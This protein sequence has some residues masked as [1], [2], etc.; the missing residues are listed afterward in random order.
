MTTRPPRNRPA[1]ERKVLRRLGAA[2]Q[3]LVVG[4]TLAWT[5]QAS[6]ATTLADSPVFATSAVPGNVALALSVE[7]PTAVRSA[8]TTAYVSTETYLGYFDPNKCYLYQY[9]ATETATELRHF[10][11]NGVNTA[12]NCTGANEWSGNYL[13][14]ASTPTIDPFRWAMTGGY[15]II[16]TTTTTILQKSRDTGQGLAPDK[17]ITAAATVA[18]ASPLGFNNLHTRIQSQGI[19]MLFASSSAALGGAVADYNPA[20][21]PVVGTVYRAVMR[22]KVCDTATAAGGV[23]A[24]CKQYGSNWKPE[25][26]IQK[27]SNRIRFS[28]FGYLNHSDFLRDGAVLRAQQKFVGPT[29]PVPGEPAVTNAATEWDATTGVFYINPDA[30]D[31]TQTN[32]D[33]TPSVSITNSGVMNYLNKFG[34]LNTN[35]YKSYD[36]VSE[37]YY[38]ALR[39]FKNQ[40]NV[41]EYTTMGAANAATRTTYL[42]DFPVITNWNDPIQY[43]C[44][45]NFILGIGDIYT[46]R[47]KNLPGNTGRTDEP[48]VPALVSGDNTFGAGASVTTWT[49]NAFTLQGLAN[50]NWND[51]SGRANSAGIVGMAYYANT[52]D[53][54]PT[55]TGN[56]ATEGKQ[57]IQ[58]YWVDVL[59][60]P[61]VAD[62]QFYLAAKYGGFDVPDDYNAATRT[63]ALPNEWWSTTGQTVGAQNRP[64][65]YFTAGRPDTMVVGLTTAFEKIAAALEAFTTSFSTSVPQ[66]AVSGNGS[67]SAQYDPN[68]WTGQVQ[69][70][71]LSFNAVG[72]PT[73]TA[74]WTATSKLAA[75]LAG[76]GWDTNRNVVT[77]DPL[78][79]TPTGVAFRS[80]STGAGR[81]NATQLGLLDTTYRA[82]NDSADYLNYL[83]GDRTHE[84]ASTVTGS[85]RA[86]RTRTQLLG[87]IVGS[88]ARPV[89]PPSLPLSDATNPGYSTF[90]T[91][92]RT[93]PTVVYVG[94]NDGMLHAFNG[95]L[96]GA[97]AGREVFAYVPNA[98]FN[99]PDG[100][101]GVSGLA[102][103]G[104]SP[105]NHRYL[106]NATPTSYDVDMGK[107]WNGSGV[108]TSTNWRSVLIGGL[109]KGGRAYYAIDVTNPAGITNEAT[110]AANVLWEFTAPQMGYTFGEPVVVKTRKY[111]WT[112]ILP[113][114]YNT[115]DGQGYLFFVNPST[116][117][118]LETVATG[119]GSVANDAGLA[120]ANAYVV[121]FTDGY[122]DAV[123]AGDLLGNLWRFD[124]TGA[125]GTYPAP[126][127]LATL[128][129][130]TDGAQPVTSRPIIELHPRTKQRV[131]MVGTGRLL[132]DTDIASTQEQTFYAIA[133][134]NSVSFNTTAMLPT[135][136]TFPITRTQLVANTD[137]LTGYT[138][139]TAKP[140]GWFVDLGKNAGNNVAWRLVSDP[141]TFFGTVAFA[142]TLP[143]GDACSPSGMSR[144]YGTDFSNGLSKLT[145]NTTVV[146]Y[147]SGGTGVITDLRFLSVDGKVRLVSGSDRGAVQRV[148]GNFGTTIGLKRLNWR[149]LPL[150]N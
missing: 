96:T 28:A 127:R 42:D 4:S 104:R 111:G 138:A 91:T 150:S 64:D 146:S 141:T 85:T 21:A 17:S 53:I 107:T 101:P 34:Q 75:Q 2:A 13:N 25:G 140:M 70:S 27:Y 143:N 74:Q 105:L 132:A 44:Q 16:D 39:Y 54:R 113:S 5:L 19:N 48:A 35:D 121:D 81:V 131:V 55:V 72:D 11:P 22:V 38:T 60:Q 83:R 69:A 78:A 49:N 117:A 108:G 135:G 73:L 3:A 7:W 6:A 120:H 114:G 23:E 115:P 97:D 147:I 95:A 40:G 106:V 12:H 43:S 41:P 59:E 99:G 136:I 14:W 92:W 80:T 123:Y 119:V 57:T 134:G 89:G 37:L 93:R 129:H 56:V 82:D 125:S 109:G 24:N 79:A 67:Y 66:V 9:Y 112:V 45:R 30:T 58:T 51:Y 118:L 77:W 18:E 71:E 139:T 61:F 15:R 145:Q 130:P 32:T 124:V 86:Y 47:D 137:L 98:V 149:E 128:S 94:A 65:N 148:P 1:P 126:L 46:H 87:D 144:I 88:R 33:F 8:H 142:P 36:P 133:D 103:L 110:A 20:V 10:Y 31:A 26:L 122:A 116:G 90:R 62:N 76:T 68:N 29:R 52:T 63:A 84:Q 100:T 102:S 50:P